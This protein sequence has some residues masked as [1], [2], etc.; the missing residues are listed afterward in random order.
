MSANLLRLI[1]EQKHPGLHKAPSLSEKCDFRA[2]HAFRVALSTWCKDPD[3]S[4]RDFAKRIGRDERTVR[5]Y[6]DGKRAVPTWVLLAFPHDIR[7]IA[8]EELAKSL[9]ELAAECG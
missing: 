2:T 3:D 4:I 5:D 9:P 8:L 7:V 1:A 6:R